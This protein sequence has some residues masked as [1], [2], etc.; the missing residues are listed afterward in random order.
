MEAPK[1]NKLTVNIGRNVYNSFKLGNSLDPKLLTQWRKEYLN[2]LAHKEN[3]PSE[4]DIED[5]FLPYLEAIQEAFAESLTKNA[6]DTLNSNQVYDL[7]YYDLQ[8]GRLKESSAF[9]LSFSFTKDIGSNF[10]TIGRSNACK[11]Y[12]VNFNRSISRLHFII[13]PLPDGRLLIV[14]PFSL[15]GTEV[16]DLDITNNKEI[17]QAQID[18]R[19]YNQPIFFKKENLYLRAGLSVFLLAKRVPDR[20]NEQRECCMC[21]D[22]F[23]NRMFDCGHA[24][25]CSDCDYKVRKCPICSKTRGKSKSAKANETFKLSRH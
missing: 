5:F 3:S 23:P 19:R 11:I 17:S 1:N 13:L 15:T 12:S 6:D 10:A 8:S 4:K 20:I 2:F 24:C 18:C 25:I 22:K 16:V 7:I 21:M 14:D 9:V